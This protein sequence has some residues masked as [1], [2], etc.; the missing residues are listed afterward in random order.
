MHIPIHTH[1]HTNTNR[2]TV[3]LSSV[4]TDQP[5]LKELLLKDNILDSFVD[6]SGLP[7]SID[8]SLG[9]NILFFCFCFFYFFLLI[10]VCF[11]GKQIGFNPTNHKQ[12]HTKKPEMIDVDVHCDPSVYCSGCP[13]TEDRSSNMCD[14][15]VDC[16]NTCVCDQDCTTTPAP[17]AGKQIF[18]F[19]FF[20]FVFF[21]CE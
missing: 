19:A 16:E 21:I 8:V 7:A 15:R 13:N 9:I 6:F 18:L 4:S 20:L 11:F 2:G 5:N 10:L 1:T 12:T 14:G 3:D 17:V